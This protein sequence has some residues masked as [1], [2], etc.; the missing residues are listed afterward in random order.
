MLSP[1]RDLPAGSGRQHATVS[2]RTGHRSELVAES[3]RGRRVRRERI[4][5][6]GA[7]AVGGAVF[8]LNLVMEF[9]T[10]VLLPGGHQ[11]AYFFAA[12]VTL[13]GG[14]WVAFDWGDTRR[15]KPS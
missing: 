14:A 11:E 15:R 9:S 13:F 2:G 8:L 7:I 5:G 6:G 3:E 4:V 10:L 1:R 12:L